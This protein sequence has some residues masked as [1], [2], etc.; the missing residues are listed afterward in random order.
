LFYD[1]VR[2]DHGFEF[3]PFKALVAPRP[4][5]WISSLSPEGV[6]NLAPYSFFNAVAEDPHY[7]VIGSG[8]GKDSIGNIEA[9]REFA[10]NMAT[11]ELREQMNATSATVPPYTD[12]FALAGLTKALCR[13]IR[14]P[15]VGESPVSFECHLHQIVDLPDEHGRVSDR[16]VI[17][18]VIGIHIDDRYIENGRVNTAAMHPIARL[19]YSEY[20]TVEKA[21]RMRRPP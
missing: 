4:I 20:T 14:A 7:V 6:A 13:M 10:V 8:A 12:E 3:D 5:G 16:M 21:W 11:F 1:A 17:G 9:T 15:R 19:G 2:N 18:R